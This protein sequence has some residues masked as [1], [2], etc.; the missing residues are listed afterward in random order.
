MKVFVSSLYTKL[1]VVVELFGFLLRRKLWW[2]V[3]LI[4]L[5]LII[6]TVISFGG[7]TGLAPFIY[8]L[9]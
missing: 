1:K 3:P 8:P 7:A 4:V 5:I 6:M 9:F 2:L